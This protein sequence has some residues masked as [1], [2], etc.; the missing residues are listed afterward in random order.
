MDGAPES[1]SAHLEDSYCV[2]SK[3]MKRGE[4]MVI[5]R[6]SYIKGS[7][8]ETPICTSNIKRGKNV[9]PF[10]LLQV[11]KWEQHNNASCV[12]N[13]LHYMLI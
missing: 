10:K 4:L 8:R 6:V 5:R 9:T 7:F 13:K 1:T 11:D 12:Y 3:D 2:P